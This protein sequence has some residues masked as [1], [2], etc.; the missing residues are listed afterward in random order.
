VEFAMKARW[1]AAMV[2]VLMTGACASASATGG[3]GTGRL[4]ISQELDR[5]GPMYAEGYVAFV[6][7]IQGS[8]VVFSDRLPF[9]Q[10]L[11]HA[12]PSGSYRLTFTVRPCDGNCGYLD[13][14]TETCAASFTVGSGDV[15][16][17]QVVER[18]GKGCS[19]DVR[20]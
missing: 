12:L 7:V 13:P 9:D 18:P 11:E 3:S 10:P 14:V 4:V 5:T 19:I 8:N 1:V 16:K 15:V 17:A 20:S 2:M 6:K